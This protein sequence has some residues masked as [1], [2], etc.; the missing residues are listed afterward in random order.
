MRRLLMV[1]A[2]VLVLGTA[3]TAQAQVVTLTAFL[4]GA[5]ETPAPVLTGAFATAV[6]TVDMGAQSVSWDIQVFNMPSGTNN[7][8]F[9][10]GGRGLGGPTVINIPFPAGVSNDYRLTGTAT[11]A[12][13][14]RP[15]QGIRSWEDALQSIVGGQMYLNI[16]SAVNGGGEVRGQLTRVP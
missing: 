2:A 15:D 14:L 4:E 9:H 10:V 6:V 5:N 16:H 12:S 13:T 1:A 7:A 11:Q 8:H 3:S